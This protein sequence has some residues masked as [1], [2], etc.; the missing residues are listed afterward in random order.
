MGTLLLRS[1]R[2]L[3]NFLA[4]AHI[5]ATIG[6]YTSAIQI[7][8]SPRL[9][10]NLQWLLQLKQRA[11]ERI[12]KMPSTGPVAELPVRPNERDEDMEMMGW[13]TRLIQRAEQGTQTAKTIL[14]TPTPSNPTPSPHAILTETI[15][16]ALQEHFTVSDTQLYDPRTAVLPAGDSSTDIM[17][18]PCPS[19]KALINS[20][21]NSGIQCCYRRM[22]GIKVAIR[23]A[24]LFLE[25]RSRYPQGFNWRDWDLGLQA[26]TS[27]SMDP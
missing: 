20:C 23:Y 1:P 17:V 25:I 14:S 26:S 13:R 27:N 10:R 11:V 9:V 19:D 6:L 3:L 8:S 24:G 18:C 12:E 7:R 21:T 2:N 16:Q 5:D 4:L 22:T 15:N